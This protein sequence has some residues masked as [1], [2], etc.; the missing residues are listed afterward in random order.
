MAASHCVRGV[1]PPFLSLTAI[2]SCV[3]ILVWLATIRGG[4]NRLMAEILEDHI[5]VHMMNPDEEME[6]SR[7]VG[8]DLIERERAYLK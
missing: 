8:E 6:P 4:V 3:D 1:R 2:S 7:G 5:R